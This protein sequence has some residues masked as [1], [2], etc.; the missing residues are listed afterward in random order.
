M[1]VCTAAS[2]DGS[3]PSEPRLLGTDSRSPGTARRRRLWSPT[4]TSWR[5][6]EAAHRHRV[7][8]PDRES[9]RRGRLA[10]GRRTRHRSARRGGV[11]PGPTA[12][13]RGLVRPGRVGRRRRV[14]D[15][16][17][18]RGA[19]PVR[20][21]N[22]GPPVLP[23][24]S[25]AGHNFSH[26]W[27]MEGHGL[28]W[29][30]PLS[31]GNKVGVGRS[32]LRR[33]RPACRPG[34][35]RGRSRPPSGGMADPRRQRCPDRRSTAAAGDPGGRA[36]T[37]P[38]KVRPAGAGRGTR[39]TDQA[40]LAGDPGTGRPP[41]DERSRHRRQAQ[42]GGRAVPSGPTGRRSGQAQA[43]LLP[44]P[45][46]PHPL[47]DHGRAVRVGLLDQVVE[48]LFASGGYWAETPIPTEGTLKPRS[49]SSGT[50]KVQCMG[51]RRAKS[52]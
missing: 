8:R 51:C 25:G 37:V 22:A 1:N 2:M 14:G 35:R 13:G 21:G 29:E 45:D 27:E 49:D 7:R 24:A 18:G 36:A 23:A 3:P 12:L 31:H 28:D 40:T 26:Q 6:T 9:A 30:P 34:R 32:P 10:G 39:A 15:K 16:Q 19:D 52:Y 38:G 33:L 17:A 46:H 11:E 50:P 42:A 20:P 44:E 4:W 48:T 5:H 43:D 47:H 41:G